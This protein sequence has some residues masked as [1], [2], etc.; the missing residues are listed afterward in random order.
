MNKDWIKWGVIC[1]ASIVILAGAIF[2]TLNYFKPR[3]E[4]DYAAM[5]KIQQEVLAEQLKK[6]PRDSLIIEKY[7]TIREVTKKQLSE[8][9]QADST[10][11]DSLFWFYY[12]NWKQGND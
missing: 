8:F 5:R 3:T 4:I 1:I 2:S 10:K 6:I 11:R 7:Y 9:E 12:L